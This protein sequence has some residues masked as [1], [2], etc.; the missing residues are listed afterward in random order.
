[1]IRKWFTCIAFLLYPIMS[2]SVLSLRRQRDYPRRRVQVCL[3][4][5]R[6]TSA[7]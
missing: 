2:S 3:T 5:R 4:D 7:N 6:V 1:M